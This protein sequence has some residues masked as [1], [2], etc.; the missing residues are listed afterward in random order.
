MLISAVL[1]LFRL[2][3]A[4][5]QLAEE[6]HPNEPD[7][8]PGALEV[9][10]CVPTHALPNNP[11]LEIAESVLPTTAPADVIYTFSVP[12]L[13]RNTRKSPVCEDAPVIVMMSV[14]A[15]SCLCSCLAY[16]P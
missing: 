10:D 6:S 11:K 3:T 14:A 1:M 2:L 13:F 9:I 15:V 8:V 7:V 5:I 16:C 4:M 12:A